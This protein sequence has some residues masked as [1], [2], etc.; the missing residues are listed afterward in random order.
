MADI[1][2]KDAKFSIIL[3]RQM[4]GECL[5]WKR[6]V[7]TSPWQLTCHVGFTDDR[8]FKSINLG[9]PQ[10]SRYLYQI[11]SNS[12]NF[13]ARYM[14]LDTVRYTDICVCSAALPYALL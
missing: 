2:K 12:V 1:L 4:S 14:G 10:V 7:H 9:Y 11:S 8:V 6:V 13:L 3:R 5:K